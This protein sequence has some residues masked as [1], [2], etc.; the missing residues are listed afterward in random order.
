VPYC[1][2]CGEPIDFLPFRCS[3]C[4]GHFCGKCRL[5]EC[6]ECTFDPIGVKQLKKEKEMIINKR[7][8]ELDLGLKGL[9]RSRTTKT[10]LIGLSIVTI[11]A[12]FFPNYLNI[13]GIYVPL[14]YAWQDYLSPIWSFFTAIF[15]GVGPNLIELAYF[16]VLIFFSYHF[17]KIIEYERGSRFL[18]Y[19]YLFSAVMTGVLGWLIS[20]ITLSV[21]LFG[22]YILGLGGGGLLGLIA[23]TMLSKPNRRW[24][25]RDRGL[26][27]VTILI[28]LIICS[29]IVKVISAM[30]TYAAFYDL[31]IYIAYQSISYFILDLYGV[32]AILIYFFAYYKKRYIGD[33]QEY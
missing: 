23:F 7:R 1:Q 21:G 16:F 13:T 17:L 19:I 24:Y 8:K 32:F 31:Y 10:L 4:G 12:Q 3:F 20:S 6:H 5:P 15:V 22:F 33:F 27:G 14:F 26:R 30:M 28:F 9:Y 29:I 25:F 11:A 18:L 2:Y